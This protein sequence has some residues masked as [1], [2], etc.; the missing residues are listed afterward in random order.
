MALFIVNNAA[1]QQCIVFMSSLRLGRMCTVLLPCRFV[2][3]CDAQSAAWVQRRRTAAAA[4]GP[5]GVAGLGQRDA[6]SAGG[7]RRG[8]PER[9]RRGEEGRRRRRRRGHGDGGAG[10]G[11]GQLGRGQRRP[12]LELLGQQ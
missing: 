2:V 6:A 11:L 8:G 12:R 4:A 10:A 5:D 1:L 9:R 7:Q 3:P